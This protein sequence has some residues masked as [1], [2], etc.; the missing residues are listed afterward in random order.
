LKEKR[1]ARLNVALPLPQTTTTDDGFDFLYSASAST[2]LWRY[3]NVL[4]LLL[5]FK[6]YYYVVDRS[7]VTKLPASESSA[8]CTFP[9]KMNS[10]ALPKRSFH[11]HRSKN[12]KI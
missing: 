2:D 10:N 11:E 1:G 7:Q 4:L 6:Y 8:S 3:I 12:V 9:I 5:F